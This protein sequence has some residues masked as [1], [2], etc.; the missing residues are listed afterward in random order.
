MAP[1]KALERWPELPFLQW[2]DTAL[3]LQLWTQI[4]GKVRL[5]LTP[6]V[7]HSWHVP[8][9]VT[10]R[11]LGTTP[12]PAGDVFLEME[13]DFI[14]HRLVC[15]TSAGE[16]RFLE[17]RP[18]SVADFHA[19]LMQ[20]LAGL[21]IAVAIGGT[22]SEMPDPVP[23]AED[24]AHASYDADAARR[25]WHVLLRADAVLKHFRTGFLG[26]VSP[27]HFFWG[28]F[29]LAV[30]RFS[31]RRAPLHPG[32]VPG[33][34]DPVTREAY[35]H[36]VSSAGFWPGSDA[37]PE[38]AF[39][40]Y[41]WPEPGGFRDW[42]MP[43]GARFDEKLGEFILPYDTVRSAADPDALLLRFLTATY[44]AA[45]E[46]AGW[47]RRGLECSLGE[48]GRPRHVEDTAPAISRT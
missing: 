36:E 25:F 33:L 3:T 42:P 45:A 5:A 16:T 47:D 17:L 26:K 43:E 12:I 21:G 19:E 44:E 15:R 7:N 46:N 10:A 20:V 9:Y 1:S 38:A 24:R 6:W 18:R 28:S 32:G 34:P 22:P 29:D 31:G 13:F 14:D 2:R 39:Y 30:T 27:V 41:S 23:F 8:L 35:S 48:A 40:A 4:V 37:F 11:G